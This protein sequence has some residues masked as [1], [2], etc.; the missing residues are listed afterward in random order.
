MLRA[1]LERV[2]RLK[3]ISPFGTLAN[4]HQSISRS[5]TRHAGDGQLIAVVEPHCRDLAKNEEKIAALGYEPVG[6][7]DLGL[8]EEWLSTQVPERDY[9]RRAVNSAEPFGARYRKYGAWRAC[10]LDLTRRT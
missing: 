2:R 9:D 10:H 8:M 3:S 1:M 4:S 7:S 5:F 6:F